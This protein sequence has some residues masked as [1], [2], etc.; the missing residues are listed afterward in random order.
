MTA[1]TVVHFLD[2]DTFGGCEQVI[3]L[4]LAGLDRERWRPVLF[5]HE[6]PGISRLLV[7]VDRLGIPRRSCPEINSRSIMTALPQVIRE[8]RAIRADVVHVHLNWLLA[9]R[10]Q[11]AAAWASR[12]P[13]IVA[14]SHLCGPIQ[15][16][17]FDLL[18]RRLQASAVDRFIAVS[19]EVR[20][21][22]CS[23]LGLKE[24]K[25]R[26]VRNGI[27][28]TRFQQRAD[29]ALRAAVCDG[30][31]RPIVFTSARLHT[32]KGHIYLLDAARCIPE[33]VFVIAGDGPEHR[34]LEEYAKQ[35]GVEDRVRFLGQREDVSGLLANC[36]VFVLPSL[37]EGLPLSVLEAMAAGKPVVATSIGGT[38]EAVV[39]G[40]TGLLIPPRDPSSMAAAIRKLL[41]DTSLA[42]R[43]GAA[44]RVRAAEAFSCESMARGV[45][46]V[47]EEIFSSR[48]H[49]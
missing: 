9:C 21:R 18:K 36:D 33:A 42:K 35:I 10:H 3:L 1:R 11:I 24:S 46:R 31:E 39:D 29:P 4:L 38:K 44:G 22:L 23:G 25:V 43:L 2:S 28:F 41:F 48:Y 15:H 13:A 32:Q 14:T 7:E 19:D 20:D 45:T 40:V 12:V 47:Y 26:V 8:L 6:S 30:C 49:T 17:R 5:H 37:Y 34:R 27:Q 16:G